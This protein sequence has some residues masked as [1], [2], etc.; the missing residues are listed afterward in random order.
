M[1]KGSNKKIG[2]FLGRLQPQHKGH[3]IMIRRIFRENDEVILCIGSAQKIK[4]SDPIFEKNP[5]SCEERMKR[6]E[7]FL[8][9]EGFY[10]P[11]KIVPITDVEPDSAWPLHLKNNCHLMDKT[12]NTVYFGDFI[13]DDYK[14]G[15]EA[16]DLLVKFIKR[17]KFTYKTKK[18]VFHKISSATEIRTLE[19]NRE[20]L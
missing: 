9:N 20:D 1:Q 14:K 4:K 11:Y 16:V 5:L 6:L 10:K 19:K 18:N 8:K 7:T 17:R 12:I 13:P 2:V 3:E 15:L